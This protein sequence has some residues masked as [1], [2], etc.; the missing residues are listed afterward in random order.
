MEGGVVG[1]VRTWMAC[2]QTLAACVAPPLVP[3]EEE[4]EDSW[5]SGDMFHRCC[6]VIVRTTHVSSSA[7]LNWCCLRVIG[8]ST[9]AARQRCYHSTPSSTCAHVDPHDHGC[10]CRVLLLLPRARTTSRHSVT[11]PCLRPIPRSA[12]PEAQATTA[13]AATTATTV[14][15]RIAAP[16]PAMAAKQRIMLTW[17]IVMGKSGNKRQM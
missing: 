1:A 5:T 14:P 3:A 7:A 9:E 16:A 17:W 10:C 13:T 6:P 4:R 11:R 2:F 15:P 12:K 8:T